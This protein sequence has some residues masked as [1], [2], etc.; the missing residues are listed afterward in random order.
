MSAVYLVEGARGTYFAPEAYVAR[1]AQWY[2]GAGRLVVETAQCVE[3]YAADSVTVLWRLTRIG[4][5]KDTETA[6][7]GTAL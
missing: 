6:V 4:N 1:F 7:E 3:C 2:G 5:I